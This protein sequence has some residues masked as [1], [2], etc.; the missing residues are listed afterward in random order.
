MVEVELRTPYKQVPPLLVASK[1]SKSFG[2]LSILEIFVI[3]IFVRIDRTRM[4]TVYYVQYCTYSTE[5]A[6]LVTVSPAIA[7]GP[8]KFRQK[9]RIAPH[10]Y[11]ILYTHAH[12]CAFYMF[13]VAFPV[14]TWA[15]FIVQ[16]AT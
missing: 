11:A 6:L 14:M 7:M 15:I 13:T 2:V 8:K 4:R 1:T 3:L 5:A 16:S 9:C 12:A 10:T